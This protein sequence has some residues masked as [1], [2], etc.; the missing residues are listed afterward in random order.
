MTTAQAAQIA[1]W[2][3]AGGILLLLIYFARS[4]A[5]G[6]SLD[7]RWIYFGLFMATLLP[8][9]SRVPLPVIPSKP[10]IDLFEA[11][12]QLPEGSVVFIGSEW[13]AGTQAENRP[14][15][16]AI[17]R[18]C[19][20]KRLKIAII[21]VGTPNNPQLSENVMRDAIAFEGRGQEG[22]DY[23]NLG[24][25]ELTRAWLRSFTTDIKE[26]VQADW[27]QRPLS[28]TFLANVSRWGPGQDRIQ[29]LVDI[30]GSAT[31]DE[32][33]PLLYPKG[34][35]VGLACTGVMAPEQYPYLANKQ[36]VGMLTGLKGAAEYE[37]LLRATDPGTRERLQAALAEA[38]EAEA[39]GEPGALNRRV[40][41]EGQLKRLDAASQQMP[42]QSAAHLYILILLAMGNASIIGRALRRAAGR[43]GRSR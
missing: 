35:K 25:K 33:R 19:L 39:R 4:T 43:P 8:L 14:Q 9:V 37:Q 12:D 29:M 7:R 2:L 21:S 16:L 38:R 15:M 24:Y 27:K 6:K 5:S 41:I 13:D 28:E 1:T 30:T 17:V 10:V 42:G 20:R 32:W 31:I 40:Q 18:H 36:I 34:V 11:I 3:L 23:V 22:V 26:Q